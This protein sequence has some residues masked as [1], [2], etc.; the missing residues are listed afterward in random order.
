ME[1]ASRVC[2]TGNIRTSIGS[3]SVS[4]EQ[5]RQLR[6]DPIVGP[7]PS[8]IGRRGKELARQIEG[9]RA[10][11]R[12][13]E[14]IARGVVWLHSDDPAIAGRGPRELGNR[15]AGIDDVLEHGD[16]KQRIERAVAKWQPTGVGGRKPDPL[17][18]RPR[19][20]A[21]PRPPSPRTRSI[22][23]RRICEMCRRP[24]LTSARP[25]HS[26]RRES[27]CPAAAGASRRGTR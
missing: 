13:T 12:G 27:D 17:V 3:M 20:A 5:R 6:A 14:Q 10:G 25:C 22:P 19:F 8:R 16:A 1:A 9:A 23:T 18:V 4:R 26:R 24:R 11:V 2:E 21:A 15:G 7:F